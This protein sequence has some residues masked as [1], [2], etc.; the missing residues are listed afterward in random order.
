MNIFFYVIESPK[1]KRKVKDKK[2]EDLAVKLFLLQY[3]SIY[4]STMLKFLVELE[5]FDKYYIYVLSH[6]NI[7]QDSW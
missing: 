6:Q 5:L 2:R 1:N 3:K 4:L 7:Y